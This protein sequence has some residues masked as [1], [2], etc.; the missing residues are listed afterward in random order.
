MIDI[1]V[2]FNWTYVSLVSAILGSSTFYM[3]IYSIPNKACPF[4]LKVYSADEYGELG[5][6][7][8]KKEA[9]RA[10]ICIA[11]EE[12]VSMKPES[13]GESIDNLVKK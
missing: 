11:I 12:R 3:F 8:F 1:A 5:A 13:L 7:A 9:R 10:N 4:L 6:D 2:H